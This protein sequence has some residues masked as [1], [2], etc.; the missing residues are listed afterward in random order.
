MSSLINLTLQR[1]NATIV[2][3]KTLK[4]FGIIPDHNS[5]KRIGMQT[6]VIPRMFSLM[7]ARNYVVRL[8]EKGI[9][10]GSKKK[11]EESKKEK[12]Y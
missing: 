6:V 11:S 3:G 10:D 2:L 9:F 1:I 8:N 5:T 12:K 7:D 4:N